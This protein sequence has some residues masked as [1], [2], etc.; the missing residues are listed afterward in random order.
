M[1]EAFIAVLVADHLEAHPVAKAAQLQPDRRAG[2]TV[3]P[4]GT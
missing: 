1:R 2:A 3:L 4:E